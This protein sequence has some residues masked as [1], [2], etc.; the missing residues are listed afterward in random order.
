MKLSERL[1]KF[2]LKKKSVVKTD[3]VKESFKTICFF[4]NT[5]IGDTLFNTPVFRVFKQHYPSVKTIALLNPKNAKLFENDPN[6]DEIIL[7]NG[8]WNSFLKTRNILK[9]KKI[10]IA[11][12][13]HSNEP[14]ATPLA[15]LSGIKYIF[16]LP[17]DRN[18]FNFL[19]SNNPSSY[20]PD[21]YVVLTRLRYLNF[22][23]VSSSD[24]RMSLYLNNDDIK[25][26]EIVLNKKTN[27]KIIGF[28]MGANSKSRMWTLE[29]W[30]KLANMILLKENTRLV[31][32]G[33][34]SEMELTN[35]LEKKINSGRV[36]NVAG[37]FSITEAAA[38]IGEF[39][40]LV[41]PDTGPLHIAAA[42]K[43]PV[44]GLF[45][46]ASPESSMPD[47]DTELHQFIKV[48]FV[49]DETYSKHKD[50]S[51]LMGKITETNVYN[52]LKKVVD[53]L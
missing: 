7:Y 19:H 52:K 3:L 26:A 25:K 36:L 15:F 12:L 17:N 4:S 48:D 42:L 11:F 28:Q 34:P 14:Q 53:V 49:A 43:T 37:K 24:T 10:D 16:K 5:A 31:L 21:G 6:L 47:F 40:V 22:V 2:I 27:E 1:L 45:G 33:S 46:V 23:G 32:I 13:L 29:R 51:E 50:Y 41:T 44:L 35:S 9:S 8:R 38:I 30:H 20:I 18:D 39:D